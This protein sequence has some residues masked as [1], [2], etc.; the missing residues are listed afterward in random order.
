MNRI[1][2]RNKSDFVLFLKDLYLVFSLMC[3]GT[4]S[5]FMALSFGLDTN[6]TWGV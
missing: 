6:L 4:L 3:I 5:Y 2:N 1:A